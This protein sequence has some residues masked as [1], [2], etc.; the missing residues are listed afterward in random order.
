[1][2]SGLSTSSWTAARRERRCRGG[3]ISLSRKT[4]SQ[5]ASRIA[6]QSST[7]LNSLRGPYERLSCS[8][9][10]SDD[11]RERLSAR[12]CEAPGV[13]WIVFDIA[14]GLESWHLPVSIVPDHLKPGLQQSTSSH[15][16]VF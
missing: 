10:I 14:R 7:S 6:H 1:M 13:T 4:N 12:S 9:T 16:Q 5:N 8:V 15:F 3:W 2:R 11:D